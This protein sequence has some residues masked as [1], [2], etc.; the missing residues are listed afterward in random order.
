MG[1]VMEI[2]VAMLV[3][4]AVSAL[5]GY[6]LYKGT[7]ALVIDLPGF[8]HKIWFKVL[9]GGEARRQ[10]YQMRVRRRLHEYLSDALGSVMTGGEEQDVRKAAD[11]YYEAVVGI[12]KRQTQENRERLDELLKIQQDTRDSSVVG[13]CKIRK[14]AVL[15]ILAAAAVVVGAVFVFWRMSRVREIG[16]PHERGRCRT[17]M[18]GLV[19]SMIVYANDYEPKQYPT[20]Q[21][22]CDLLIELHYTTPKQFYCRSSYAI[23]GECSYAMNEYVAGKDIT[24]LPPDLVVLFETSFGKDPNGRTALL[25]DRAWYKVMPYGSAQTP[26][27]EKR[28]NQV[29]GAEVLT[30]ENHKGEGCHVA[31]ADTHVEFVK[32][33][34][35][36]K[37]R[38]K[39]DSQ[40][41]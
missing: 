39:P 22:W 38:W 9:P 34:N 5:L 21:R 40:N 31:F 29:G 10:R 23:E 37:L 13:K 27:Y 20:S 32:A 25:K 24:K 8:W 30:V 33:R 11:S 28:W 41:E 7:V 1:K 6:L 14:V 3:G 4:L 35:L 36:G 12:T 17:N 19:K 16:D 26:V 15:G 2:A 18:S